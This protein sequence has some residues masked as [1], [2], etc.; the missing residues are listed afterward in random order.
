MKV[1]FRVDASLSIGIGHGVRCRTLA[2]AL[3]LYGVDVRFICRA[4]SG[5]MGAALE[6]DGFQVAWLPT[7]LDTSDAQDN[8]AAWLGVSQAT[9]ATD[10]IAA[11]D[12]E[13]PD[14]LIVDH[15]GLDAEWERRP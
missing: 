5:H 13:R 12:G 14:W 10:T 6:R 15:Y 2:N 7:V 11:L 1:A 4:H 3:R 8:Y 9:D